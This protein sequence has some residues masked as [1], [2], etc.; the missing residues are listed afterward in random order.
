LNLSILNH[1][2]KRRDQ[3]VAVDLS[4]PGVKAVH[5]RR[6]GDGLVL[7]DY[8]LQ[9]ASS[10]D[11][12]LFVEQAAANLESARRALG[13]G[14]R[15]T[16]LVIG[17][18]DA[19]LRNV[20]M[21]LTERGEMRQ[22]LK[23]NPQHFFQQE[24]PDTTFD[25]FVPTEKNG[26]DEPS[27]KPSRPPNVL[28]GAVGQPLLHDLQRAAK[29]ACVAPVQITLSQTS[30]ANAAML[31]MTKAIHQDPLVLLHV[32]ANTSAVSFLTNGTLALTRVIGMGSTHLSGL[33]A[34]AYRIPDHVPEE[35]KLGMVKSSLEKALA[36]FAREARGAIDYFEDL[37]GKRVLAGYM[38][39]NLAHSNLILEMLQVLEIPCQ[40]LN[41]TT[42]LTLD[43]PSEKKADV[44]KDLPRLDAAIGAAVGWLQP[45]GIEINLLA[46]KI[47][48]AKQRWRDPVR[49]AIGAG[50]CLVASLLLWAGCL[51]LQS[52]RADAKLNTA[53]TELRSLEKAASQATAEARKAGEIGRAVAA[54]DQHATNRFLWAL[55]LNALQ[56]AT[57]DD[58][59]VVG[60]KIEQTLVAVDPPK[61]A[62]N[63]P[64]KPAETREQIVLSITAKNFAD[65]QAEDE[66]IER[67]ASVPY[68]TES[69]RPKSPVMLKNRSPRQVDP[70]DP[71][72]TFILLT[73]ECVYPERVLGREYSAPRKKP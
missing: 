17:I 13:T 48:A 61:A 55:P 52:W 10:G 70:L 40:R 34:E 63:A 25:C 46:E 9:E 72:K 39:G 62:T 18:D 53:R 47:E 71:T 23:L 44:E 26:A 36:P 12:G 4:G 19:V 37:Q 43:V 16:V 8:F 2:A 42:F 56:L 20:E 15:K 54:L 68:F 66:F 32:G 58:I 60:L 31:A 29:R 7:A 21:P 5:L 3:I 57:V 59:Q 50:A 30:V 38:T 22:M 27:A 24:M 35:Y 64:P 51:N 69:L 73:I 14:G 6:V 45:N 11:N 65:T 1:S 33:L 28:V 49:W 67:L 41:P